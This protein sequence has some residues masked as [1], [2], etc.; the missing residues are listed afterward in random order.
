[1]VFNLHTAELSGANHLPPV[2]EASAGGRPVQLANSLRQ[3]GRCVGEFLRPPKNVSL[4]EFSSES[5]HL[6]VARERSSHV[7]RTKKLSR[8]MTLTT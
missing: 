5:N 8:E 2:G 6:L 4:D 7:P 3:G 1:M